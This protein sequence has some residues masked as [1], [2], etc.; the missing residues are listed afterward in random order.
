MAK[1][2][3]IARMS[4]ATTGT[5]TLTLG[6]A[7]TGFISFA[8]A[9]VSNG[10][11]ITY[12]IEDGNNREIGRG[13]YTSS[14]TTLTRSVLKSTNSNS[15]INLSGSAE[16]F[17]TA[18]AEDVDRT[19]LSYLD[20]G[21]VGDGSTDNSAAFNAWVA[22][23]KSTKRAGYI[24]AGNFLHNSVREIDLASVAYSGVT[25]FGDGRGKS[26]LRF[27]DG[28]AAPN[29]KVYSSTSDPVFHFSMI[30]VSIVGNA[31]GALFQLAL[32]AL[33]DEL[34]VIDLQIDVT[35]AS[36]NA[37]MVAA[38]LGGIY[39]GRLDIIAN[40]PGYQYGTAALILRQVQ[41]TT[42]R[43]FAGHASHGIYIPSGGYVVGNAVVACDI[44]EVT[45]CLAN[46]S[47]FFTRN[48]F[49]AGTFVPKPGAGGVCFNSTAGNNNFVFSNLAGPVGTNLTGLSILSFPTGQRTL[50]PS[51]S[52]VSSGNFQHVGKLGLGAAAPSSPAQDLHFQVS[53]GA[54]GARWTTG[55]DSF[56][57]T[58]DGTGYFTNYKSGGAIAFTQSGT[59]NVTFSVNGTNRIAIY[60]SGN[61]SLAG[62]VVS[63]AN[64]T[65]TASAANAFLDS[66]ASNS[67]LRSTSSLAYKDQVE[68]IDPSIAARILELEPIWYRS[69]ASADR[70]D[71]SWYGLGAEQVAAID[72]RLVHWGYQD[73]D[74]E[75][76]EVVTTIPFPAI[77]DGEEVIEQREIVGTERRLKEGAVKK[78]D[79]VMYDR[80]G[81]LLLAWIK[82]QRIPE[83]LAAIE[84]AL[85][86]F[87]ERVSKP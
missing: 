70:P 53:S 16:V 19:Y 20:F 43:L 60:G 6:S 73:D 35:N 37:A 63:F 30:G 76:V 65:T 69:K 33:T 74:F 68:L 80:L 48:M 67:L 52:P 54:T 21:A 13:V 61:V 47:A 41:F 23:M 39:G 62:P 3:N 50:L 57:L 27:A 26:F 85:G 28:L 4:T 2:N 9:G 29:L 84:Q 17:I 44:E 78:P 81:V 24:P 8:S 83:R 42:I 38:D 82:G 58:Y 51:D 71:W 77:V 5:G 79:G 7:V 72:P 11:V 66:G 55:S 45:N 15:A 22:A 25:I 56:D 36:T 1:L 40:G 46:D 34:N 10:D 32:P 14:G 12:A 87:Y 31:A 18:A 86:E 75:T 59:G 64:I 49:L